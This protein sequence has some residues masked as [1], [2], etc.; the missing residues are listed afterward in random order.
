[1]CGQISYNEN[2][3]IYTHYRNLMRLSLVWKALKTMLSTYGMVIRILFQTSSIKIHNSVSSTLNLCTCIVGRLQDNQKTRYSILKC[4][5]HTTP[6]KWD[7]SQSF[8][9]GA[10]NSEWPKWAWPGPANKAP[11]CSA[12]TTDRL[13]GVHQ[14]GML[15]IAWAHALARKCKHAGSRPNASN[16]FIGLVLCAIPKQTVLA[17]KFSFE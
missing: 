16:P 12:K 15:S 11:Q 6:T 3:S 13:P 10:T 7:T 8:V 9:G 5:F 17:A 14:P 4:W 1:M 2:V